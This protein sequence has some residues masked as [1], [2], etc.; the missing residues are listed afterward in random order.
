[1]S[2]HNDE[3]SDVKQKKARG[4]TFRE[5]IYLGLSIPVALAL[6]I[7]VMLA[8][9][10]NSW[11]LASLQSVSMVLLVVEGILLGLSPVL[12]D[13]YS[14]VVIGFLSLM[15]MLFSLDTVML[16]GIVSQVAGA[17]VTTTSNVLM[18]F[19]FSPLNLFYWN[20]GFFSASVISYLG[21]SIYADLKLIRLKR[22]PSEE[23]EGS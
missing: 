18:P 3:R 21:N 5:W 22:K 20:I 6:T 23:K 15:A 8:N 14:R 10:P 4:D 16:I 1:M 11:S 7:S 9:E 13:P 2:Q 19:T 12:K 17:S